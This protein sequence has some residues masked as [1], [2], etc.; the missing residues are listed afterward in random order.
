MTPAIKVHSPSPH[1]TKYTQ[2]PAVCGV[3]FIAQQVKNLPIIHEDVG[4][5]P[6]LTRWVKDL[7][8]P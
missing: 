8:L 3:S 2:R 1:G 5:F 6:G 4:S 7:V